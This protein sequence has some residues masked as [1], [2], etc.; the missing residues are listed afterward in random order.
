MFCVLR[1]AVAHAIPGLE[2]RHNGLGC[3]QA[4][5]QEGAT[6]ESRI[7]IWH[8]SLR[9]EGIEDSG[10]MHDHRFDLTSWVLHGSLIDTSITPVADPIGSH[11]MHRVV[12]ARRALEESKT[13][14]GSVSLDGPLRYRLETEVKVHEAFS[15]YFMPKRTFHSTY[16]SGLAVTLVVKSNQEDVAA[17][18]L[19]PFGRPVSHAFEG[20]KPRVLWEGL[21][22]EAKAALLNAPA[23][24]VGAWKL[25]H[26]EEAKNGF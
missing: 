17:R 14:D 20:A 8:P 9:K 13:R 16:P 23:H 12:N 2:W 24:D 11:V 3:L 10:S 5:L 25:R 19:A 6:S 1:A 15:R 22:D 18:I 4:Y 21:L 7:H 26:S